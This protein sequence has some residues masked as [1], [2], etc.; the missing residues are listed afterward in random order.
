MSGERLAAPWITIKEARRA[1]R[2]GPDRFG[3]SLAFADLPLVELSQIETRTFADRLER[4]RAYLAGLGD[5]PPEPIVLMKG[6]TGRWLLRD[7]NHRL[8]LARDRGAETIPAV[9]VDAAVLFT[10]YD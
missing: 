8:R 3:G 4:V 9:L 10:D 1:G 6:D 7:G 5:R 2:I